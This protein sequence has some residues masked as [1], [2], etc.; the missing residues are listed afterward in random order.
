MTKNS[1]VAEV[2]FKGFVLLRSS[3][4][5]TFR[6]V[7]KLHKLPENEKNRNMVKYKHLVKKKKNDL[8]Q[9]RR[10]KVSPRKTPS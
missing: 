8:N 10:K 6:K 7:L 9:K 5:F 4:D 1:F 3:P 2:T